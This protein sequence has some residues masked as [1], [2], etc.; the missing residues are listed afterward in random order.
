MTSSS[1]RLR[2]RLH[3]HPLR[4]PRL[5]GRGGTR[6]QCHPYHQ[7]RHPG[8]RRQLAPGLRARTTTRRTITPLSPKSPSRRRGLRQP[9][10]RPRCP[11]P[12]RQSTPSKGA[13]RLRGLRART[14]TT[15]SR[16]ITPL[17]PK[18]PSRRRGLRSGSRSFPLGGLLRQARRVPQAQQSLW[19][20]RGLSSPG[21][22]RTPLAKALKSLLHFQGPE[23]PQSHPP[24]PPARASPSQPVAKTLHVSGRT[25]AAA[26]HAAGPPGCARGGRLSAC[27][28]SG[29][30]SV[31]GS[32]H[33]GCASPSL[34]GPGGLRGARA[35]RHR[36]RWE[37]PS[38]RLSLKAPL[39]QH[40][41]F[42]LLVETQQHSG[43]GPAPQATR[44]RLVKK[45]RTMCPTTTICWTI[46]C[47]TSPW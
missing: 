36:C 34:P 10:R 41:R 29:R 45:P 22:R 39:T 9:R 43:A 38:L 30:R 13:A 31:R 32:P 33:A 47:R 27:V 44:Q 8:P 4:S 6:H 24:A 19:A 15:T 37:R 12:R 28:V 46:P 11:G 40:R 35:R 17:S 3:R 23:S 25:R 21:L 42:P 26:G 20:L 1:P 14:G 18:S 7:S 5:R 2:K 16:T